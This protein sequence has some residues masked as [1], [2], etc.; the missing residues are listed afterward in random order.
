MVGNHPSDHSML[1]L[2]TLYFIREYR[3]LQQ[4]KADPPQVT[5]PISY[6]ACQGDNCDNFNGNLLSIT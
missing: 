1:T 6:Y 3:I 5:E 2:C 4:V